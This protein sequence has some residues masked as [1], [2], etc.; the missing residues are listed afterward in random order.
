MESRGKNRM[1]D[2]QRLMDAIHKHADKADANRLH[3][4]DIRAVAVT[5]HARFGHRSEA[6]ILGQLTDVFEARGLLWQ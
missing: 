1:C 3:F 4:V 5:L 6:D 2:D